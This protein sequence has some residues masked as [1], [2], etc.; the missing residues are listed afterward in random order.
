MTVGYTYTKSEN[1]MEGEELIRI[2]EK[3]ITRSHGVT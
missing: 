2:I 1:M 3:T